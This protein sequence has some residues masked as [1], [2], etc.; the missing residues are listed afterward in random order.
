MKIALFK[1]SHANAKARVIEE[2]EAKYTLAVRISEWTEVEFQLHSE[3]R[4]RRDL[5]ESIEQEIRQ[6]T[7]D[8]SNRT[9]GDLRKRAA[10]IREEL[11]ALPA[12]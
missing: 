2:D 9:L 11:S 7:S 6:I 4:I 12:S 3:D 1:Y 5:L 10:E 8:S